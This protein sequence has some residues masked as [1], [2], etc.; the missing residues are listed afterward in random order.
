L[1]DDAR[2]NLEPLGFEGEE[3]SQSSYH[4]TMKYNNDRYYDLYFS[5]GKLFIITVQ[6]N[7][8]KSEYVEEYGIE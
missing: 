8:S 7:L 6:N 4:L 1:L 5:D 3:T 2:K